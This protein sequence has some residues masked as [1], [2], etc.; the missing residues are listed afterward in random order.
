VNKEKDGA[1]SPRTVGERLNL[2][3]PTVYKWLREGKIPFYR[4]PNGRIRIL[5][6]DLAKLLKKVG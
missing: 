5:E 6:S 1:L 2:Q 3:T 4:L